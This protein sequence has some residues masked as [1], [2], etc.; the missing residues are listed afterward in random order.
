MSFNIHFGKDWRKP[1]VRS[2]LFDKS[3]RPNGGCSYCL[4]NRFHSFRKRELRS[5]LEMKEYLRKINAFA[6]EIDKNPLKF[7][8]L[9]DEIR[10]INNG[11]QINSQDNNI[12][13]DFDRNEWT[14]E[15]DSDLEDKILA[16]KS[17]TELTKDYLDPSEK[18]IFIKSLKA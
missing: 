6:D 5:S 7:K 12:E 15:Y 14:W 13:N 18:E 16:S 8:Y 2:Q 4:E 1:Y 9:A 17:Q 10:K 11:Y 3:C